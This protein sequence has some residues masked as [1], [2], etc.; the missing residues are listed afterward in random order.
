M[1]LPSSHP[2]PKV[3]DTVV[4]NDCGLEQIF[5]RRLGMSHMKTLRMKITDVGTFS[6][7]YPEPTYSVEVDNEEI[8]QYLIDHHCFDI[9]Q[10]V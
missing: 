3:G 2:I 7:T 1:R 5:N 6:Y 8:N 10:A 9:V 4:I